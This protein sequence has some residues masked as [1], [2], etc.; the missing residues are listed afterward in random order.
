[1]MDIPRKLLILVQARLVLG[2]KG[3]SGGSGVESLGD[4]PHT[5]FLGDRAKDDVDLLQREL[6]GKEARAH[7]RLAI[8]KRRIVRGR[9]GGDSP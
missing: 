4:G 6:R 5:V 8:T 9:R 2:V 7:T 1:M 3:L